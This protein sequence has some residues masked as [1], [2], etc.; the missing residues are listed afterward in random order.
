MVMVYV[1]DTSVILDYLRQQKVVASHVSQKT[2]LNDQ[3]LLVLPVHYEV[4]R[5]LAFKQATGQHYQYQHH[6]MPLFTQITPTLQDWEDAG[7]LWAQMRH[8]GRT[9]SDIDLLLA[10]LTIRLGA[11][12]VTSDADFNGIH[13]QLTLTNW[14]NP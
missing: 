7:E 12:L 3:L 14:R 1:L 4:I 6:L 8:K 11:V 13:P 9:L 5:S 2:L 10:A